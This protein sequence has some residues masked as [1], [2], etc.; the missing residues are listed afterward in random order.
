MRRSKKAEAEIEFDDAIDVNEMTLANNKKENKVAW[1]IGVFLCCVLII[2]LVVQTG[3]FV[4]SNFSLL[5]RQKPQQNIEVAT[6]KEQITLTAYQKK[7]DAAVKSFS[8]FTGEKKEAIAVATDFSAK[9]LTM[10]NLKT[11]LDFLG[12]EYIYANPSVEK[13]FRDY[14]LTNYY[15][16][17][18]EMKAKYG[19]DENKGTSS[20]PE[21]VDVTL[22]TID[23]EKYV[24][25]NVQKDEGYRFAQGNELEKNK[26]FMNEKFEGYRIDLELTYAGKN[27]A[28]MKSA[29]KKIEVVVLFDENTKKWFVAEFHLASSNND[30]IKGILYEGSNR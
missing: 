27:L 17:F 15:Y 24:H 19:N 5:S 13:G 30:K 4:Y 26:T 9:Y 18:P 10:S 23:K 14:S 16:H 1:Y 20:M 25:S 22:S 12:G 6:P 11:P 8:A 7:T 29:P 28:W 21:I 2:G 3:Y